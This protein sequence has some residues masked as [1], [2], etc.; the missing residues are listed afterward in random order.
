MGDL[1]IE[2]WM[3]EWMRVLKIYRI[4]C[5]FVKAI[6]VKLFSK[7]TDDAYSFQID[8]KIFSKKNE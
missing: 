6:I 5:K 4:F 3:I 1:L 8:G 7:F 2:L